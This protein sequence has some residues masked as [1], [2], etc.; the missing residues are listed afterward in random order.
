MNIDIIKPGDVVQLIISDINWLV[1]GYKW[2]P[3]DGY[4]DTNIV[5]CV[6]ETDKKIVREEF[7]ILN[8]KKV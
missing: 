5:L 6:R 4:Y 1:Y 2:N 3:E 7:N 8:L